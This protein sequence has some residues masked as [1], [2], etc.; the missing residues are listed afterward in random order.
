MQKL[1]RRSALAEKQAARRLAKRTDKATRVALKQRIQ[2]HKILNREA[3]EDEKVARLVRREDYELG[4]LAPKRDV[5]D[6]KDTYG[7]ISPRRM[8][9]EEIPY[10]ERK[11][12][13]GGGVYPLIVPGDRVVIL[14]GMDKG[15]IGP[16]QSIDVKRQEIVVEGLNMVCSAGTY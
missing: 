2:S 7:T 13:M 11:K 14:E 16:V 1:L 3:A 9:G 8:R 5:G 10:E 12:Q 4:P 6:K 15:R